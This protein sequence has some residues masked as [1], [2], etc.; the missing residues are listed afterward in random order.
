MAVREPVLISPETA[1]YRNGASSERATS[2]DGVSGLYGLTGVVDANGN[3]ELFA[4]S[5]SLG[6][7]DPS[8]LHGIAG[9]LG[10]TQASQVGGEQFSVLADAPEDTNFKGVSFAP[11]AA[12]PEPSTWAMMI[13]GFLRLGLHGLSQEGRAC[14]SFR[15]IFF[16][17]YKS[18]TALGGS[19]C[20]QRSEST[21]GADANPGAQHSSPVRA[22]SR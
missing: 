11:V 17:N 22:P 3:V 15:L 18:R 14:A 5:Y 16:A 10:D 21:C 6:D 20:W 9:A 12:V 7:T 1:A 13:L 4:T 19:F 2:S 8:Y